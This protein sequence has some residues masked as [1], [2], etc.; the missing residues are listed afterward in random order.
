MTNA[1]PWWEKSKAT[2]MSSLPVKTGLIFSFRG[3][4]EI[5]ILIVRHIKQHNSY[6][7]KILNLTRNHLKTS[8]LSADNFKK[9]V[10]LDVRSGQ[11]IL[12]SGYPVL[13]AVNWSQHWCAICLQYQSSCAPKLARKCE[14]E[15]W[16]PCGADGRAGGRAVYVHVITKFSGMGRFTY[17]W[18]SAGALRAPELRYYSE[19]SKFQVSS[20]LLFY[21]PTDLQV[22]RV[23]EA[24]QS[25]Q[26]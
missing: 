19:K 5:Q 21:N 20:F 7:S 14:I 16:L 11:V 12:V 15:H 26:F 3:Q 18:C 4:F 24:G 9:I 8:N 22:T 23:I 1:W 6:E 25:H 13:T 2:G 10:D 17:P